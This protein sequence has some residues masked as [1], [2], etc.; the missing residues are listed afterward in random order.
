MLKLLCV[1]GL[2]AGLRP[3][4]LLRAWS[5]AGLLP[6]AAV[7][8]H[9]QTAP[10]SVAAAT[11]ASA[12]ASSVHQMPL[13]PRDAANASFWQR[14]D[15][16]AADM[17][18]PPRSWYQPV[19]RIAGAPGPF[20]PA[21]SGATSVPAR[22]LD[23]AAQFVQASNGQAIIVVHK[24]VVQLERYFGGTTADS[25]FSSHSFAKTLAAVAIGAALRDG[26]IQSLDQP[27]STWLPE[28]RDPARQAITLRQLLSMSGGFRTPLST[29]PGHRYMQMHYGSDVAAIVHSAPVV[30][31]PGQGFAYDNDNLHPLGLVIERA[32]GM[33]Y[34][35][36][37][38]QRVWQPLGATDADILMDREGGRAMMYCC[39]WSLPRDWVRLGQML[40][41]QGQWQGRSVLDAGYVQAMQQP[42]VANKHFGL[43]LVLG[44]GWQDARLSR[45]KGAEQDFGIA[46][47]ASDIA[48]LTGAGGLQ[49]TLVPSEQL[50]ILRVGK[51][52]PAWRDHVLP[53][54]LVNALHP[55]RQ[56]DWGWLYNWRMATRPAPGSPALL[57]P[58]QPT[59][60]PTERVP[61]AATVTPLPRRASA[62]LSPQ[63]LAPALAEIQRTRSDSFMVWHDGAVVFEHY[64][65]GRS[66]ETRNEPASMHKSVLALLVGQAV[67]DGAIPS[68]EAPVKRWLTEWAGDA[69]GDITVRQMLQMASGLA[70]LP[71]SLE[72]GSAYSRSLYGPDNS[73][74]PLASALADAPGSRF[75]YASGVSQL[76]GLIVERATGQRYADYLARRLWQPL[77]AADAWVVLDH[78]GGHARTSSG[79]FARPED[80]VRLGRLW[81]DNGRVAGRGV[82]D[83]AW[84]AAMSASSPANPN[85]GY[86]LWRGSPHQPS[87]AY[88]S[89]TPARMPA[90]EPF[91][92]E[93][94]VYFDGAGAQRM[95]ASPSL[96]L[97]IVRLGPASFDWDDS[98]L[99]NQVVRALRQCGDAAR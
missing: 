72:P 3:R 11:P 27:A 80:W 53:N 1:P 89:A 55:E 28:W 65:P 16:P 88:N 6:L 67:A 84:L 99:P 91:L 56:V 10:A 87:R 71:F 46:P 18:Q 7:A 38:S 49:L 70:P 93:D 62:C 2:R 24:G 37:V 41:Q 92:A 77:G 73:E 61:G 25:A 48:Y 59:L 44:A 68:V 82:V 85:Y 95:Y 40:L 45:R 9:A 14:V 75:N 78:P 26:R 58:T 32:T 35:Q 34:A 43:Q 8:V 33:P 54:L 4:A 90:R 21:A 50:L 22:A 97:V 52:S 66:G 13:P 23:E 64:G 96:K 63:A 15:K 39:T 51:G 20:L 12:P 47:A 79:L 98:L 57:E 60:W 76:L 19:T 42:S 69:R 31:P 29:D 86:Q 83:P 94:M 74:Q 30:Y 81:L 5:M 17:L 36:Y